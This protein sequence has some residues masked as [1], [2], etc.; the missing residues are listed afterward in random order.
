MSVVFLK[1][2]MGICREMLLLLCVV[3]LMLVVTCVDSLQSYSFLVKL[4][5]WET[6]RFQIE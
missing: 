6:L 4:R 2:F 3:Q 5:L 1:I